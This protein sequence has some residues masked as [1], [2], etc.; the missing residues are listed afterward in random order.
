[1]NHPTLTAKV[2][3]E[4]DDY[5]RS[6][7]Y[8]DGK[9]NNRV[10]QEILDLWDPKFKSAIIYDIKLKFENVEIDF[11]TSAFELTSDNQGA[12][13]FFHKVIITDKINSESL[14]AYIKTLVGFNKT[15]VY[16]ASNYANLEKWGGKSKTLNWIFGKL[17]SADEKFGYFNPLSLTEFL[18]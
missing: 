2:T 16:L 9:E 13:I 14:N 8:Y 10:N 12:T 15:S 6:H 18:K 4:L 3:L 1:M 7:N 17:K 5:L 11:E